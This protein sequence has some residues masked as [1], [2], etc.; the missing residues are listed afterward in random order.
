MKDRLGVLW[1]DEGRWVQAMNLDQCI[2]VVRYKERCLEHVCEVTGR[3]D[4]VG[5]V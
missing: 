2:V 3:E 1:P 5:G 4:R